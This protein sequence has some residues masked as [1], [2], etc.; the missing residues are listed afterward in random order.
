MKGDFLTTAFQRLRLRMGRGG[1]GD[2]E[3][4]DALQEAFCRLWPRRERLDDAAQAEGMLAAAAR[5]IRI[6]AYRRRAAH[7]AAPVDQA[8]EV[9]DSPFGDESQSLYEE[10]DAA[11]REALG[12]RDRE[13][14]LLRDRDGLEFA[15]IAVRHFLSDANVRMIVSRARRRVREIYRKRQ[16][17][18]K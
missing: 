13:I 15:E 7:P 5:N 3:S 8:A 12:E 10:V 9:A 16:N 6:D 14:L 18:I 11:V 4:E 17:G 1:R 2:D